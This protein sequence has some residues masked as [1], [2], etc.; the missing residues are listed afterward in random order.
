[1]DIFGWRS[2]ENSVFLRLGF[3]TRDAPS[4][5]LPSSRPNFHSLHPRSKKNFLISSFIPSLSRFSFPPN[6]LPS[7]LPT[8]FLPPYT[9]PFFL[10]TPFLSSS[11]HPSFLP[12]SPHLSLY[13]LPYSAHLS[14]LPTPFLTYTFF[15]HT[16]PFLSPYTLSVHTLHFFLHHSFY[17]ITLPFSLVPSFLPAPSLMN[18]AQHIT[19]IILCNFFP[20]SKIKH[21]RPGN[22]SINILPKILAA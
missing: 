15:F 12:T 13:N 9:L 7:F 21:F 22:F 6:I 4:P 5:S 11:L 19:K 20:A 10:P 17:P 2:G 8:P 1:M 3:S 14:L 18:D 16:T